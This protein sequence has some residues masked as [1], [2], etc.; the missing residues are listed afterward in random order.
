MEINTHPIQKAVTLLCEELKKHYPDVFKKTYDNH[1]YP[2]LDD[3]L[4]VRFEGRMLMAVHI[5]LMKA[6][7]FNNLI[8]DTK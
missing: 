7:A 2:N 8:N 5:E 3:N 1:G 4:A 6:G